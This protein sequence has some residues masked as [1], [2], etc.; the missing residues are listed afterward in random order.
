MITR[1]II[2]DNFFLMQANLNLAG[3]KSLSQRGYFG[4]LT[5]S[6]RLF[7]EY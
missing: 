6:Y 1:T 5:I 4:F 7:Y 2:W 3:A